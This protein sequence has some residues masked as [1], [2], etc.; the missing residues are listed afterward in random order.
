MLACRVADPGDWCRR[1]GCQGRA[2]DS[3]VRRLAHEPS[4][5][6]TTL[7]VTV[8][9]C[10]CT[11][12]GHVW[13]QDTTKA[14]A[15]RAKRVGH[16]RAVTGDTMKIFAAID[17]VQPSLTTIRASRSRVRGVKTALAWDTKASWW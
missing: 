15:P 12:C 10:A 9:R 14:A 16:L 5:R 4:G 13:R 7:Q 3:V 17:T 2:R 8:R 1:C 11:G 6:P